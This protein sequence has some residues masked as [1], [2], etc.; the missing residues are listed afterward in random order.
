MGAGLGQVGWGARSGAGEVGW[1]GCRSM[2]GGVGTGQGQVGWGGVWGGVACTARPV[3][4]S[5]SF[6]L[7][8][9][10]VFKRVHKF[11]PLQVSLA[12][13]QLVFFAGSFQTVELHVN[14][15]LWSY[16]VIPI[17]EQLLFVSLLYF[18]MF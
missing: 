5:N 4:V 2:A 15:A 1:R 18:S 7:A 3:L 13:T 10:Q 9:L 6:Q 14:Y 17:L 11:V 16:H 12:C 8:K